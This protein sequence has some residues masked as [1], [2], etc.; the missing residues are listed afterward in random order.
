MHKKYIFK[1]THDVDRDRFAELLL[2]AKGG[3]TMKEFADLCNVNPSTFTRISQK[4]NKGAS[5]P[6]LLE[7]IAKNAMP[8]SNF[9]LKDLAAANGYTLEENNPLSARTLI[10][11]R[12]LMEDIVQSTVAQ[13][14]LDRGEDVRLGS[15]RYNVSKRMLLS[16]DALI[17][18]NA[19][20]PKNDA[21]RGL[22]FVDS[23]I[24]H[25]D[26][27]PSEGAYAS[28]VRN[29]AFNALSR[30]AFIS[31]STSD[32]LK[33]TR[34]SLAVTEPEMFDI[35]IDEFG[36]IVF[37]ADTTLILIDSYNRRI[38]N[39][40]MFPLKGAKTR[41]SFFMITK[42]LNSEMEYYNKNEDDETEDDE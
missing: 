12:R 9:T 15:I 24:T 27:S 23:I 13:E 42:P 22:W 7:A 33:P 39:E 40:F 26:R 19:F 36:E 41:E 10:N 32:W 17:L 2:A 20:G 3:R 14:L 34:F 37:T 18:T 16:P 4:T 1:K 25:K 28:R 11:D 35:I 38:A 30:F 6:E 31:M 21:E 29:K 8:G 5:S